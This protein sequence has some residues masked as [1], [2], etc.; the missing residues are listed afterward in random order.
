MN[1]L[2]RRVLSKPFSQQSHILECCHLA[3][4]ICK[5]ILGTLSDIFKHIE[6]L[7]RLLSV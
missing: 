5:N 1:I 4:S 3:Q 2:T 7:D 6:I